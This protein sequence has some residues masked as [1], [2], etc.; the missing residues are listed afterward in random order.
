MFIIFIFF[1]SLRCCR[2]A[3]Y[4]KISAEKVHII[5]KSGQIVTQTV[6]L[7]LSLWSNL[8]FCELDTNEYG[9]FRQCF[10][11]ASS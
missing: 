4:V 5:E 9:Q 2:I 6:N 1:V 7:L 11:M 8:Q 10:Y 3:I